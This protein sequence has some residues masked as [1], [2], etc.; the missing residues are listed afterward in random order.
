[1]NTLRT[2][3]GAIVA[4]LLVVLLWASPASSSLPPQTEGDANCDKVTNSID[5][6]LILQVDAGLIDTVPCRNSADVIRDG[7]IN[8]L[9]AAIV[10][11]MEAGLCCDEP[12]T[13][14]LSIDSLPIGVPYGEPL[15][16]TLSITN[17]SDRQIERTYSGG[18]R[19][20]FV[21]LDGTGT[22]VWRWAHDM[23]FIAAIGEVTFDPG[24]KMTYSVVWNQQTNSGEQVAPGSYELYAY[25]VGGGLPPGGQSGLG[26]RLTFEILPPPQ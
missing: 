22:E 21:V 10:L 6:A 1:M 2:L 24:E 14:E 17:T 23:L 13:A 19:Y 7:A 11:Q 4:M 18:Q 26:A 15:P 5:A 12:L 25:D 9:D 3:A 16:M 20:D 8:S